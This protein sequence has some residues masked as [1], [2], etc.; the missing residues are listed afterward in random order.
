MVGGVA[1]LGD[2][3]REIDQRPAL[4]HAAEKAINR[5]R[6]DVERAPGRAD[7][8]PRDSSDIPAGDP[9]NTNGF[10]SRVRSR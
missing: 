4:R 9:G 7:A 8:E 5:D 1:D 3:E 6:L 10:S 2:E